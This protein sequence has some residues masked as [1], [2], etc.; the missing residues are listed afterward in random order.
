VTGKDGGSAS[1]ETEVRL[2]ALPAVD[3]R[4]RLALVG[5][6]TRQSRAPEFRAPQPCPDELIALRKAAKVTCACERF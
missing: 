5:L 3:E 6:R 4:R 2:A 1:S